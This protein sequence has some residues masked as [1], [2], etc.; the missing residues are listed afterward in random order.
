M[1]GRTLKGW[2]DRRIDGQRDGR[3]GGWVSGWV[4]WKRRRVL[5]VHPFTVRLGNEGPEREGLPEVYQ[6]L[7]DW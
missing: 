7:T 3:V 4:Y 6:G 1:G 2:T 5:G